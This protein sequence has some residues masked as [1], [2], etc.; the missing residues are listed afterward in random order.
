[1]AE[2]VAEM[3]QLNNSLKETLAALGTS[4][5]EIETIVARSDA[6][7]RAPAG[8]PV[9]AD[10]E[11]ELRDPCCY[12]VAHNIKSADNLGSL[13]RTAGAFGAREVLVVSAE[14]TSKRLRK[15]LRTFGAHGAERRV[16]LRAFGTLELLVSWVKAPPRNCEIFGIE[17]DDVAVSCAAPDAF[18]A[19]ALP[20]CFMPGNEGEGLL[21]NQIALCDRLVYVPQFAPATAS[22][23]VNAAT[24]VV[25]SW[26]R[27]R[28][29][30]RRSGNEYDVVDPLHKLWKPKPP[31]AEPPAKEGQARSPRP[32]RSR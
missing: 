32:S 12:L 10:G 26:C 22:L 20:A 27:R 9:V 4:E 15:N 6:A 8:E 1:M 5:A 11:R 14:R 16:P 28:A 23:N 17:I 24:A 31:P 18:G 19:P 7:A 25:L 2:L 30:E 13:V 21:P 3:E 29:E